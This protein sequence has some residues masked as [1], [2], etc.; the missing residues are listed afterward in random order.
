M[1]ELDHKE[2]WV[3]RIDAFEL[4][5]WKT[6]K[7]PLDCK[8]RS[9]QSILK[10]INPEYSAEAEAPILW[11]PE[12]KNW[13]TGKDPDAGKD[14]MQEKGMIDM[15]CLD[16]ITDAMDISVSRL[17]ELVM[18]REAWHAVVHGVAKSWTRP[19]WL[20][21][22]EPS[23]WSTIIITILFMAWNSWWLITF[24]SSQNKCGV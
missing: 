24:S 5:C 17:W 9:N 4:W 10:E 13:L 8:E 19:K 22:T 23:Q 15:R 7:S 21:W 20:K 18:D 2:I 3:Q 1:S 14:W 6:L 12:V 16:G 11:P